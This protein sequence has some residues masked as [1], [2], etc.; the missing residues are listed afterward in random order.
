MPTLSDL[1]AAIAAAV[2]TVD[3]SDLPGGN[4]LSV[5]PFMWIV[6]SPP[7]VDIYPADPSGDDSSFGPA[8]SLQ[9]WTV[10]ARVSLVDEEGNQAILLALREPDGPTS[11]RRAILNDEDLRDLVEGLDV[12]WPTGYQPYRA[13]VDPAH[14]TTLLGCEWRVRMFVNSEVLS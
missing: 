10:R 11:L 5:N 3:L 8:E 13:L 9:F 6:P 4:D 7:A 2:G 14:N 12:E 1:A